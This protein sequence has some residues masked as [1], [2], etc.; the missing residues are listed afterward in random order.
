[1]SDGI[2]QNDVEN[3]ISYM[4]RREHLPSIADVENLRWKDLVGS[5]GEKIGQI[6]NIEVS[7]QSDRVEFLEV[8]H[9]GFLGFHAE[10]FLVPVTAITQVD[11]KQV[12]IDRT[13]EQLNGVPP[14]EF[15]RVDDPDYYLGIRSWWSNAAEG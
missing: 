3:D 1:M 9:G 10:R 8:R 7:E 12:H 15:E 13:L 4:Y 5:D 11:D 2:A 14:Y 6:E